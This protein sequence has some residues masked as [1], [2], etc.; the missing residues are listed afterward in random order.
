MYTLCIMYIFTALVDPGKIDI[1]LSLAGAVQMR[2]PGKPKPKQLAQGVLTI[3]IRG[4]PVTNKT[5]ADDVRYTMLRISDKKRQTPDV[6]AIEQWEDVCSFIIYNLA[7]EKLIIK[8]KCRRL[9]T[10]VTLEYH[11]LELASFPLAV[12]KNVTTVVKMKDG[13]ELELK[14]QYTPLPVIDLEYNFVTKAQ[15][16]TDGTVMTTPFVPRTLNPTWNSVAEF[17]VGDF[18]KEEPSVV[19]KCLTLGC[20]KSGEGYVEDIAYGQI[21]VSVVFRPVSSVFKSERFRHASVANSNRDYLYTEDL[22]SPS[23]KPPHKTRFSSSISADHQILSIFCQFLDT[24]SL[25]HSSSSS[26]SSS[27]LLSLLSS[28][29]YCC[30]PI[31]IHIVSVGGGPH[32]PVVKKTSLA[33]EILEDK[34]FV[35]FTIL[36]AKDLVGMDRNGLSDPFCEVLMENGKLFKTSVKK[37]TL[38]PKWNESFSYE[39]IDDTKL[40]EINVYDKDIISKDFLGKVVLSMDKLKEISH[41]GKPEWL[42]LQRTKSGKLQIKCTVMSKDTIEKDNL[43]KTNKE[44]EYPAMRNSTKLDDNVFFPNDSIIKEEKAEKQKSAPPPPSQSTQN[45]LIPPASH[46]SSVSMPFFEETSKQPPINGTPKSSLTHEVQSNSQK[47]KPGDSSLKR[48]ASDVNVNKRNG[49]D[50]EGYSTLPRSSRNLRHADSSNSFAART[51]PDNISIEPADKNIKKAVKVKKSVRIVDSSVSGDKFYSVSGKVA[52]IRGLRTPDT[53]F[54]C[55]VRLEDHH[56]RVIAKSSL[57]EAVDPIVNLAFEV[58][59][60]AGV[61]TGAS[62]IFDIKQDSKEHLAENSF[63]LKDLLDEHSEEPV[64]RW[65]KLSNGVDIEI[66]LR[67]GS[68][69]LRLANKKSPGRFIKSWSFRKE[70]IH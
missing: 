2:Q 51:G 45:V 46:T 52:K 43:N 26:S 15:D 55:K 16:V 40:I 58:D 42:S 18:T 5:D 20:I 63:C 50:M 70:K 35:D 47:P 31:T 38:F 59:R 23:S 6:L 27:S 10:N 4:S 54:Y 22:V 14:F 8:S 32:S 66:V 33:G 53:K 1:P 65:I 49:D 48:S 7:K 30:K 56:S 36:Q 9:L 41:K 39:V 69:N 37:N 68:P 60:G 62:L 28:S 3:H 19:K 61:N 24:G 25:S 21:I 29:S 64:Q 67:R 57:Q 17:F 34:I 11:C 13:S 44:R 12:E